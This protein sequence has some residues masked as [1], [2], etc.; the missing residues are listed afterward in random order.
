MGMYP[1]IAALF[2]LWSELF[3]S[4]AIYVDAKKENKAAHKPVD[5]VFTEVLQAEKTNQCPE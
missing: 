2:W 3:K 4:E 1:F 5:P